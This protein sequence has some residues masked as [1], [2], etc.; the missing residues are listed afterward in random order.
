MKPGE[1]QRQEILQGPV[2]DGAL[3]ELCERR[4]TLY[5]PSN[6]ASSSGPARP[7]GSGPP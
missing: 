6:R 3:D 2:L 1:R 4:Q 7:S 5:W